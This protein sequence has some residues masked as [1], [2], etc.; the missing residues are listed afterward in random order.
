MLAFLAGPVSAVAETAS[1]A[2][3]AS[4][5]VSGEPAALVDRVLGRADAPV[6]IQEFASLTCS[7]CAAFS[8]ETMPKLKEAYI[9]TGKVKLVFHD[10]PFDAPGLSASMLARCAPEER[11]Y[12]LLEVLFKNLNQWSRASDPKRALAQIGKLA[13]MSQDTIDACWADQKLADA[14][15]AAR[16]DFQNHYKIEATPTFVIN[17]GAARVEGAQPFAAFAAAIDKLLK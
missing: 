8:T 10:F 16:L 5:V 9:D 13:G 11:Y 17:D 14:I 4:P 15:L 3:P 7:H 6:T 2:S 12:P 1:P